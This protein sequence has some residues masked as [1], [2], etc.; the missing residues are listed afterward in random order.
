MAPFAPLCPSFLPECRIYCGNELWNTAELTAVPRTKGGS[1]R[2]LTVSALL[3]S[4]LF[5]I[6]FGSQ[7]LKL[8]IT[9]NSFENRELVQFFPSIEFAS[10]IFLSRITFILEFLKFFFF[11]SKSSPRVFYKFPTKSIYETLCRVTIERGNSKVTDNSS[12]AE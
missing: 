9:V 10:R 8:F 12:N 3:K 7:S 4:K 11:S 6:S 5:D 1:A 2:S